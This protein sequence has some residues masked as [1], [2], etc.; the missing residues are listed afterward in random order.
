MSDATLQ[1]LLREA[2]RQGRLGQVNDGMRKALLTAADVFANARA[3]VTH[4]DTG[5]SFSAID[6]TGGLNSGYLHL[7]DVPDYDAR[8]AGAWL[9]ELLAV[10]S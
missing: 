1:A 7:H 3:S 8:A 2:Q 5:G 10:L 6:L 4:H 9:A